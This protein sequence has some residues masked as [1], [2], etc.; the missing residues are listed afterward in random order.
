MFLVYGALV[1]M[2]RKSDSLNYNQL[3][4]NRLWKEILKKN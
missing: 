1:G 4:L 3:N 2:L